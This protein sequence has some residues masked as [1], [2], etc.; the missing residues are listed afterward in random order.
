MQIGVA[1]TFAQKSG[2]MV[3]SEMQK[4]RKNEFKAFNINRPMHDRKISDIRLQL[5]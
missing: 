4:Q 1:F 5:P 2:M 3:M